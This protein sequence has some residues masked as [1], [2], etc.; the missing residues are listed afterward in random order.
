MNIFELLKKGKGKTGDSHYLSAR[1]IR[2][3]AKANAREMKRLE[4]KKYRKAPESEFT[5]VMKDNNNILEIDDL[6]TYFFTD[7]G[8]VKA[9]NGISFNI[10]MHSSNVTRTS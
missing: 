9:V 3:N 4:N 2:A 7:Q 10:P 8:V 6:H 5:S 1:E